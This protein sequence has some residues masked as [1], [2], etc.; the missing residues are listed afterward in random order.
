M[1]LRPSVPP[2]TRLV[3]CDVNATK[4]PVAL[5]APSVLS[6]SPSAPSI[7]T[8]TRVVDGM[9]PAG[10][11]AHVSRTKMSVR[12]FMSPGTRFVAADSKVTKRPSPLIEGR[13]LWPF[14]CVPSLDIEISAVAPV[15][16][17]RTKMS[18]TPLLSPDMRSLSADSQTTKRPPRLIA[19]LAWESSLSSVSRMVERANT[20]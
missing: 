20:S 18:R 14:A 5:I 12:P 16:V 8:E 4:R 13:K 17:S 7:A 15:A 9:Q 1:Y 11:L 10:A 19:G 3:A 6:L 2:G